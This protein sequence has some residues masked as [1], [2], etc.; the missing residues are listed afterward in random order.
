MTGPRVTGLIASC[1]IAD[2]QPSSARE[3]R[4]QVSELAQTAG[5]DLL[6]LRNDLGWTTGFIGEDGPPE[7]SEV[8]SAVETV[9]LPDEDAPGR[10]LH[11]W[12]WLVDLAARRGLSV[13]AEQLKEVPYR[14]YLSARVVELCS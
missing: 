14:I 1:D 4:F 11:P 10:E 9:V 3:Y 8:I 2:N 5:G 7:M 6:L 12:E 13:T